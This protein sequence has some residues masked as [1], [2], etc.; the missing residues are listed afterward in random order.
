MRSTPAE[1]APITV[2]EPSIE[3]KKGRARIAP[4][5]PSDVAEQV[6]SDWLDHRKTKRAPVT[7]TVLDEARR[8]S[9]RAGL[10]LERFLAI[11]CA[12]GSQGLQADWLKPHERA[13]PN[14]PAAEPAWRTEQR[15][16]MAEFAPMA[17]ARPPQPNNVIDMEIPHALVR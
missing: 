1:S 12:R 8:E 14:F 2:N 16:R 10:P 11:W 17:A 9:E 15:S 6:W 7:K 3:P 13:S 4:S 5:R